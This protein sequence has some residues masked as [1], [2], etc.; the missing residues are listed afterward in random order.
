MKCE[1]LTIGTELMLGLTND[2]NSCYIAQKLTELGIV[3]VRKSSVFDDVDAISEAI[4]GALL[5][6]DVLITT[7]GLGSTHD[8]LTRE[9]LAKALSKQL[10]FQPILAGLIEQKLK[11]IGQPVHSADFKQAYLPEGAEPIKSLHGIVPGIIIE[12]DNKTIFVLPGVSSEMKQMMEET[13]FPF[14][15]KELPKREI[16]LIRK[17]KT[18]G[19]RETAIEEKTK[20]IIDRYTNPTI[21]I[22]SFPGEV[23]LQLIAKGYP[24]EAKNI[25][26]KAEEELKVALGKLV[27]G[28]DQDTLEEIVGKLLKKHKLKIAL[29]ESCTGGHLSNRI[30]NIPES[31]AY[32][33]GSIVAYSNEIKRKL[34]GVSGEDILKY[35]AVSAP[36]ALSMAEGGRHVTQ[37]DIALSIT[38][39]AGP[40][41]GT[42]EK[43]VGLV[44]VGLAWREGS[45]CERF[46]FYGKRNEIKIKASQ[47]ALNMLRLFLLEKFE[48]VG[49]EVS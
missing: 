23:Q 3:C 28:F 4:R 7:G 1:I 15:K 20:E 25:V 19:E 18:C 45:H 30:T 29:V 32:F 10:V 21:S 6:S 43:P 36:V 46:Q 22:L 44:F 14:I 11:N 39:V 34:I 16:I 48:D 13:V 8:D 49:S 24:D 5:R 35:G 38:G 47:A 41:G 9:A 42:K 12:H 40:T 31:S 17:I 37:V 26:N 2:S 33:W 27:F